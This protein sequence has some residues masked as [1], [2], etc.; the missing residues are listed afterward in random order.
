M[1][2]RPLGSA[3]RCCPATC[4]YVWCVHVCVLVF[5]CVWERETK[6]MREKK[7]ISS[8]SPHVCSRSCQKFPGG[9]VQTGCVLSQ[10]R[11][12]TLCWSLAPALNSRLKQFRLFSA[13]APDTSSSVLTTLDI[14]QY[15]PSRLCL[16]TWR[17]QF[18]VDSV[19]DSLTRTC[20]SC[21]NDWLQ[22]INHDISYYGTGYF[23]D[24]H[25]YS[26][27]KNSKQ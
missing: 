18:V 15:Y 27:I 7:T 8:P 10:T 25:V 22:W 24:S 5:V 21:T 4:V 11:A 26:R 6:P 14:C 19:V 17:P 13:G 1:I 12:P 16:S 3:A 20:E 23:W 9:G 2:A